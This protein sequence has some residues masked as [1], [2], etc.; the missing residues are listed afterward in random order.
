MLI[1]DRHQVAIVHVPKCGGTSITSQLEPFDSYGGEFRRRGEHP[2]LGFLDFTHIPLRV[3]ATHFRGEFE[4]ISTY[5]SFALTRDPHARFASATFH[6]LQEYGGVG[7]LDAT[8]E[9]AFA[10]AR[11]VMA[12]LVRRTEFH[13]ADYIHFCPQ[14]DF[15]S[16]D[17]RQVVRNIFALEDMARMAS[18]LRLSCGL[19]IDP[20]RRENTNFASNNRVLSILHAA[21]P[22]YS[23]LTTWS[24]RKKV[25][26]I[27]QKAKLQSADPLYAAFR[28]DAEITRFVEDYYAADFE[29]YR[30][31][32]SGAS[33]PL[34]SAVDRAGNSVCLGGFEGLY[35]DH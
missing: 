19:N 16:L 26:A 15:V 7:K 3:L 21:K 33:S 8:L 13:D 22:V 6:R 24:F 9:A 27:L 29:L 10:E 2:R 1:D 12:W 17:G 18:V 34:I 35:G 23:R 5:E 32:A 31:A 14:A 20:G 28:K 4:K 30:M 25:M 11:A